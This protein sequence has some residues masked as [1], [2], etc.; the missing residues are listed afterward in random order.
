MIGLRPGYQAHFRPGSV[1]SPCVADA[2]LHS[3]SGKEG[4]RG[5][6]RLPQQLDTA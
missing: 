3:Y 4:E 2:L 5:L 1:A 6:C